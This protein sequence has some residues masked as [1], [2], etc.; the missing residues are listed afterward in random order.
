MET[1]KPVKQKTVVFQVMEQLKEIIAKGK[2]KPGDKMPNE[3]ELAKMFGV[4][5]ST[6]REALK[7]F[8]YLGIVEFRNPKG[9][10][11]CEVSRIST[12]ALLWAMLLGKKNYKDIVELRLVL[13]NQGLWHL[14]VYNKEDKDLH[15][16]TIDNLM[17]EI[18]NIEEAIQDNNIKKRIKAD[19]NF[20]KHIIEV[21]NNDIFTDL[22][23]T[24]ESFMYEE[25]EVSQHNISDKKSII[26]DHIALVN[27]ILDGNYY[28]ATEVFRNHIKDIDMLL[29]IE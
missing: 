13:E 18:T 1:I 26:K 2:L 9:T 14:M 23:L 28:N 22:Y 29:G 8:Q 10:F 5:R 21:C 19:Y 24:M 16:H 17:Q 25:I 12:E 11:I 7:I 3:Y 6:I 20:H 27:T 4:G 15:K